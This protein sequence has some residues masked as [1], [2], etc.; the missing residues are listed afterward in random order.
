MSAAVADDRAAEKREQLSVL[1]VLP[2]VGQILAADPAQLEAPK[3]KYEQLKAAI[4][5]GL[6][7][8][9]DTEVRD[10]VTSIF[11][12]KTVF[13]NVLVDAYWSIFLK[14]VSVNDFLTPEGFIAAIPCCQV[15]KFVASK[16]KH[17]YHLFGCVGDAGGLPGGTQRQD[18]E[19]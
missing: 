4:L 17:Q 13:Q 5:E 1:P 15:I 14:A 16:I 9:K 12:N 18:E 6:E 3:Q 11:P 8:Q 10:G 7:S 19:C 2:M